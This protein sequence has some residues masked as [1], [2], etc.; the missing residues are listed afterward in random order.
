MKSNSLASPCNDHVSALARMSA[1]HSL[2]SA[3]NV[4]ILSVKKGLFLNAL[5]WPQIEHS[6]KPFSID[7]YYWLNCNDPIF[8]EFGLLLYFP[9]LFSYTVSL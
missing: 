5:Q 1:D 7:N 9:A 6:Y 8:A 3:Y 2:S 4:C